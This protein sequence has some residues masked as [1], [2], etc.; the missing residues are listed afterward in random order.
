LSVTI[1][2]I[3]LYLIHSQSGA[4]ADTYR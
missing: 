4:R 1:I 3:I 2:I